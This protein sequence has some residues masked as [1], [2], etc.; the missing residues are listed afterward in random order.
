PDPIRSVSTVRCELLRF[1][2]VYWFM[3]ATQ[4]KLSSEQLLW[5]AY[6]DAFRQF[7]REATTLAEIKSQASY[8]PTEAEKALLRV[9]HARLAYDEVRDALAGSMMSQESKR[10]LLTIPTSDRHQH[11]RVRSIAELLWELAGK[12]Q[13]SA[14]DDWYRAERVVRHAADEVCCV[15]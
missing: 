14:D 10:Q 12:P 2:C 15:R 5:K 8:D 13:G 3:G 6:R 9:E 11:A 7:E 4:T 1:W